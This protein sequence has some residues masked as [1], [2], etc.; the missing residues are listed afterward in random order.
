MSAVIR[1]EWLDGASPAQMET[2]AQ[3]LLDERVAPPFS[4][5]G[6]T[7]RRVRS[8]RRRAAGQ[9][10]RH[11]SQGDCLDAAPPRARAPAQPSSRTDFSLSPDRRNPDLRLDDA[12]DACASWRNSRVPSSKL[13]NRR[14]HRRRRARAASCPFCPSANQRRFN[15]G[16]PTQLALASIR[17]RRLFGDRRLGCVVPDGGVRGPSADRTEL[18]GRHSFRR[19]CASRHGRR[20]PR[21]P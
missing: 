21:R 4:N 1:D 3:A 18:A 10:A 15:N 8:R 6:H 12:L 19:R 7:D 20:N 14:V 16:T 9:L 5:L 17:R 2:L 11:R 13:A